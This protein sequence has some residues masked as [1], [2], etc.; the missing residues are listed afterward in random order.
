LVDYFWKKR[1][2]GIHVEDFFCLRDGNRVKNK[3]RVWEGVSI[4]C[5]NRSIIVERGEL[6]KKEIKKP[7]IGILREGRGGGEREN[8]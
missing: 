4:G 8:K 6:W 3:L 2:S 1:D 7:N 5:R